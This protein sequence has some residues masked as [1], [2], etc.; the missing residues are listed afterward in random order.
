MDIRKSQMKPGLTCYDS[1]F[2]RWLTW[3]VSG[4]HWF[5]KYTKLIKI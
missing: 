1:T 3:Q 5:S 2:Q 4:D